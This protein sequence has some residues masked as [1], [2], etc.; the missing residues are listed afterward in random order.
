MISIEKNIP[1]AWIRLL[2]NWL[3]ALKD[4]HMH[5]ESRLWKSGIIIVLSSALHLRCGNLPYSKHRRL[6]PAYAQP[7]RN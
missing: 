3:L 2:V 1:S 6:L 5:L 7:Y 4:M